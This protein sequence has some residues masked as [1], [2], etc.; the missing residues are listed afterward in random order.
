MTIK[1]FNIITAGLLTTFQDLGR[2]GFGRYGIPV[3][4]VM[5][6]FAL[7]AANVLVGNAETAVGLEVTLQGLKMM[8]M[9]PVFIAVTGADL[10]FTINSEYHAPWR[11]FQLRPGDII[12]FEKR[13]SGV[14]AYVAVRGGFAAPTYMGSASVFVIGRMGSPL[15]KNDI[16]LIGESCSTSL[17]EVC[18][19]SHYRPT[20]VG[21]EIVRVIADPQVSYFSFEGLA[22]FLNTSFKVKS[23]SNRMAYLLQGDAIVHNGMD[24]ILSQP[25]MPGSIQVTGKGDLVVLMVDGQVT[26]GYAKIANIISADFPLL[27]QSFPGEAV[28]FAETDLKSAYHAFF[29]KEKLLSEIKR[30][31]SQNY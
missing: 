31:I 8:A 27:S 12:N 18:L 7:R 21:T 30:Q 26:G 3:S 9:A 6:P 11:S 5:D 14:R 20:G 23:E 25:V 2:R 28:R 24:S 15:K 10:H 16:L 22:T 1:G 13:I 19:S 29:Q 4:G 17:P